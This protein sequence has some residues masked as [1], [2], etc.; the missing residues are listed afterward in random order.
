MHTSMGLGMMLLQYYYNNYRFFLVINRAKCNRTCPT[1]RCTQSQ[2]RRRCDV[3]CSGIDR[4]NF[5]N[6]EGKHHIS[7][8]KLLYGYDFIGVQ[9][10]LQVKI[11][12]EDNMFIR[13]RKTFSGKTK[14]QA[15]RNNPDSDAKYDPLEDKFQ[16]LNR[17]YSF[18]P[19][20]LVFVK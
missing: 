13:G 15:L 1:E 14:R 20:P 6:R 17:G 16:A 9:K 4:A 3:Q 18:V 2:Y 12:Q 7:T 5:S 8:I 10:H 19:A 11:H